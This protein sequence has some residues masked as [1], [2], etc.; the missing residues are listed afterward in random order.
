V[1]AVLSIL[2]HPASAGALT[3]GRTRT[4]RRE[5]SQVRPASTRL[6]QEQWRVCIPDVYPPSISWDTYLQMQAMRKDHHAEYDRNKTRGIP[7][8]GTALLPGLVSCGEG[9]HK[10][11]V[12]SKGGTRD[13]CHDLRQQSRTPVQGCCK[14]VFAKK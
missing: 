3:Y 13:L 9:G 4:L 11:V 6:P 8:P 2:T 7:R 1:A 14:V 5:A 12:P 10:M